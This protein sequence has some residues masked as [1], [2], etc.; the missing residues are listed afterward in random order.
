MPPVGRISQH[1]E[2]P[3]G[4]VESAC[5]C[6][7]ATCDRLAGGDDGGTARL[8]GAVAWF[9]PGRQGAARQ[10]LEG[11]VGKAVPLVSGFPAGDAESGTQGTAAQKRTSRRVEKGRGRWSKLPAREGQRGENKRCTQ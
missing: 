6:R 11:V 4:K 1:L 10:A 9:R 3:A 5:T 2:H 7:P 8:F